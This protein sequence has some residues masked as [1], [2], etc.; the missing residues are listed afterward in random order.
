MRPIS[1][2]CLHCVSS[3]LTAFERRLFSLAG[4][5]LDRR[6]RVPPLG[7]RRQQ[8][9]RPRRPIS[10]PTPRVWREADLVLLAPS[11]RLRCASALTW[12]ASHYYRFLFGLPPT[13]PK[14][15]A[16]NV[17]WLSRA[18]MWVTA[19]KPSLSTLV[20]VADAVRPSASSQGEDRARPERLVDLARDA[21]HRQR[22]P[23]RRAL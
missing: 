23:A 13:Q 17:L 20:V 21:P 15:Q 19:S 7:V 16:I 11:I 2:G 5:P 4:D 10:S 18:Q 9:V 3:W 14:A 6:G 22:G 1:V 12:G 8:A